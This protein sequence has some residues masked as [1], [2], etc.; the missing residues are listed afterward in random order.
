MPATPR[1]RS[2]LTL[3]ALTAMTLAAG[4]FA[5]PVQAD[6]TKQEDPVWAFGRVLA[7]IEDE[8]VGDL[9]SEEIVEGAI[10]GMLARLDPHS[11]YLDLEAFSEMRD[12]QRGKFSGLGI[13]INKRGPESPLTIVAPIEGTPAH[14][15]GLQSGDVISQINGEPTIDLTVNGAVR[16]LKGPKGTSVTI[17]IDRPGDPETFDVTIERDDIPIESIRVA[18]ML[19][20]G[21]GIV[22]VSNFT[23]TTANELDEQINRL[24]EMGMNKLLLDLRGNPGRLLDQAVQVSERFI[25]AGELV[26]YTRGRIRGSSADYVAKRGVPRWTQ[27]LVVLVDNA[28]ASA[29]EIVSGA[30]QDHDRGLIVGEP[31]FGKGLV[32][33]V[34]PLQQSGG[35]LAVTTAKYY[36]P[37]GR[38]IQRDYSDFEE[39]YLTR[40]TNE[41]VVDETTEVYETEGGRTVYGGGGIRPDHIVEVEAPPTLIYRL[42]RN[43]AIFDFSIRYANEHDEIER[44]FKVTDELMTQFQASLRDRD[45]EFT[46]EEFI[47]ARDRIALRI[48]AQIGRL[49]WGAEEESRI[50]ADNDPQVQ[51]ALE[52]FGEAADLHAG[53]LFEKKESDEALRAAAEAAASEQP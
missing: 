13:Q 36:T 32:Q 16:R 48:E 31:T 49:K 39:Y 9:D 28:S 51:R 17:T 6:P 41:E 2:L 4:L 18:H 5:D 40:S 46:E 19:D 35:A 12:E 10:S 29:S 52:L 50:L 45:L 15:A 3:V 34:I 38:L 30:I 43:N 26:V 8:Y 44:G 11:N 23:S 24:T 27:P 7:L 22:R 33:R 14:R 20:N 21:V 47:E 42:V 37:L 25:P 1:S 53:L